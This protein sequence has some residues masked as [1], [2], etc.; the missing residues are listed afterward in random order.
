MNPQSLKA[1]VAQKMG[2]ITSPI[3]AGVGAIKKGKNPFSPASYSQTAYD[4]P[5]FRK[6]NSAMMNSMKNNWTRSGQSGQY[7]Y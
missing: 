7:P 2:K 5:K 3:G 1:T 6:N 4:D